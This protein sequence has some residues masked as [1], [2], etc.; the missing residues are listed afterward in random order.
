MNKR[1]PTMFDEETAKCCSCKNCA[2]R[3]I[4]NEQPPNVCLKLGCFIV[5]DNQCG[6]MYYIA[7]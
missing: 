7:K 2:N 1:Y 5:S 4:E 6:G 3:N